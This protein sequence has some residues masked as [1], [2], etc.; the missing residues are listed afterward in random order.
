M[1]IREQ[2]RRVETRTSRCRQSHLDIVADHRTD[3]PNYCH[4]VEKRAAVLTSFTALKVCITTYCLSVCLFYCLSVLLSL[5]LPQQQQE[6]LYLLPSSSCRLLVSSILP[7]FMQ[8]KSSCSEDLSP[9]RRCSCANSRAVDSS[10]S[11]R[12][13]PSSSSSL[14]FLW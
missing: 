9:L 14:S 8:V 5:C 11:E 2:Q 6:L 1:K 3:T 4:L 7:S 13:K 10:A 12:L